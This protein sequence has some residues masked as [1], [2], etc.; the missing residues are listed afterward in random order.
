MQHRN[1]WFQVRRM[2]AASVLVIVAAT[3]L[4]STFQVTA[5]SVF[6]EEDSSKG[7][8]SSEVRFADTSQAG[9]SIVPASCPSTPDYAGECDVPPVNPGTPMCA[10]SASPYTIN[11]GQSSTLYW[12]SNGVYNNYISGGAG[13]V[14]GLVEVNG[15]VSVTPTV[16]TTY[17]MSASYEAYDKNGSHTEYVYCDATITVI[18]P[19]CTTPATLS[20]D[21]K[22]YVLSPGQT[23]QKI[24]V[25]GAMWCI[26]NASGNTYFIPANTDAETTSFLN[27][28]PSLPGVTK[29]Q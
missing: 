15:S 2:Q 24:M 10:M 16:D 17:V 13:Q 1:Q 28:T 11:R 7:F 3:G 8:I 26:S 14:V 6:A 18:N 23:E 4:L 20:A 29:H 12:K 9:L 19:P 21:G 25:G 5:D 27:S 22:G